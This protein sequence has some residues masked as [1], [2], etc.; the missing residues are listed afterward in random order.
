[1]SVDAV[2]I[3]FS[4]VVDAIVEWH[5]EAAEVAFA[6]VAAT[7]VEFAPPMI[8][9]AAGR[10]VE[11]TG[12]GLAAI[13]ADGALPEA[14]IFHV[15]DAG[16]LAVPLSPSTYRRFHAIHVGPDAPD[17]EHAIWLQTEE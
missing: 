14:T 7:E 12:A 3:H 2:A 15:A 1:M 4:P 11:I 16:I 5:P 9:A 17:D 6:E 8:G 10:V 13:V